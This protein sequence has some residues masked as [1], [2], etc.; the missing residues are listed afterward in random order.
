MRNR[1]RVFQ[2]FIRELR[3]W[4]SHL[5]KV[6]KSL[7]HTKTS[8]FSNHPLPQFVDVLFITHLINK[9]HSSSPQDFYYGNIPLEL[10]RM[11]YSVAIA[12]I[13]MTTT[14]SKNLAKNFPS[15]QITRI[16]LNQTLNTYEEIDL[17]SQC[18]AERK[19][20]R[21]LSE[22]NLWALND[23][24]LS[25]AY[26]D[27]AAPGTTFSLRIGKQVA[28][29]LSLMS[30]KSMIIMH[31]GHSW[32]R[33]VLAYSRIMNK[34]M[35][36]IAYQHAPLSRLQH[37]IFQKLPKVYLPDEII[38]SGIS[39]FTRLCQNPETSKVKIR[40]GGSP[41]KTNPPGRRFSFSDRSFKRCLVIPEG[42][43][44]ECNILYHFAFSCAALSRTTQFIIRTH[45]CLSHK[46]VD[47]FRSRILSANMNMAFSSRSLQE[48]L[49]YCDYALYRGSSTI[50]NA[51]GAGLTPI[52]VGIPGE[53][54]IDPL[55]EAQQT[56][57]AV[58]T[59][60]DFMTIIDDPSAAEHK[61]N[62]AILTLCKSLYTP[63]NVSEFVAALS[64]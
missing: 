17:L 34:T 35:K 28:K 8:L 31:E 24:V 38:A 19:R 30:A 5:K 59:P 1:P 18:L 23:K 26:R 64:H 52:Y 46:Q 53:L 4:A 62:E 47:Y 36:C 55:F 44:E 60:E 9:E 25:L 63:V 43:I 61:A 57:I 10:T 50:I 48:D 56:R 6:I 32:E 22:S 7:Y 54:T 49:S 27:A 39:S 45:P 3:T 13:N 37:A 14:C 58:S 12:Y 33:V 20:L 29:L 11:G 42:I 16:V 15:D 21:S 40:L 41:R 51:V 2:A